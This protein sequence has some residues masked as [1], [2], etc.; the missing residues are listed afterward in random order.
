MKRHAEQLARDLADMGFDSVE[1]SFGKGQDGTA[2][3]QGEKG[4]S[5]STTRALE[6][7]DVDPAQLEPQALT[8]NVLDTGHRLDIRL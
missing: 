4:A 6:L 2:E 5:G 1:L 8:P 7:D 3:E